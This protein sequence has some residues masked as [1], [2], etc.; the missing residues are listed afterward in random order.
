MYS[1]I[2]IR[3]PT[4]RRCLCNR[5]LTTFSNQKDVCMKAPLFNLIL[6]GYNKLIMNSLRK[7][8]AMHPLSRWLTGPEVL[9]KHQSWPPEH[10]LEVRTKFCIITH[11]EDAFVKGFHSYLVHELVLGVAQNEKFIIWF[12][13]RKNKSDFLCWDGK[14]TFGFIWL[15]SHVERKWTLEKFCLYVWKFTKIE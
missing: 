10:F 6:I 9:V 4:H 8:L 3:F 14:W 7:N 11:I 2:T 15:T 13:N 12:E 5:K 1:L